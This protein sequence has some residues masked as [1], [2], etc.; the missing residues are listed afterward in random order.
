MGEQM[1]AGAGIARRRAALALP[2]ALGLLLSSACGARW[3]DS[4]RAGVYARANGTGS[5][6]GADRASGG[7]STT[8]AA[9]EGTTT[10]GDAGTAT[11]G[12]V[13]ATTGG[14]TTGGGTGGTT[15]PSG[16]QPCAAPST[17]PG[18]TNDTITLGTIATNSGPLPGLG[19]SSIAAVRAYIAYQNSRGGVCGRKI[20]LK[21]GDDGSENSRFRTLATE[22]AGS[23]FG[24]VGNFAA[25]DGGGVDVVTAQKVPVVAT[26]FTDAFQNAPTVF[27]INPSPANPKAVIGKYRYLYD[28]GVRK[29]SVATLAQAQSLAQLNL[30]V[31]QMEAAGIKVVNRQELPLSTLSFDAPARSVANSGADYF[32]FL[33]AGNLNSSMARSIKDSGYKGLKFQE[34]LTAYGSDFIELAGDAAEG[35]TGWSR[36]IPQEERG[37]NAELDKFLQWMERIA[38]GVPADPFAVDSWNSSKAFLDNLAALPGPITR[39]GLI[40][41]LKSVDT[42]DGAGFFGPIKLGAKISNS[43]YVA[44]QVVGGK[45]KRLAPD[46]GFIC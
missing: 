29:A 14:G 46:K 38:P 42:Y 6:A 4:E 11:D 2:V 19:E 33:G 3:S 39:D 12:S 32:L 18:V 27:D 20:V 36:A 10:G 37:T 26:A 9:G 17:A 34:Y 31:S 5:G 23:T 30:Q 13:G 24:L 22:M 21:T 25:G 44:M 28:H 43:C 15:G 16:P 1:V 7:T 45:W 35:V 8:L 41:K 40:A